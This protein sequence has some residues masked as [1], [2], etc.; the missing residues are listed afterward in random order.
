MEIRVSGC[1]GWQHKQLLQT[2]ASKSDAIGVAVP[3]PLASRTEKDGKMKKTPMQQ[4]KNKNS[5]QC[6]WLIV[7]KTKTTINN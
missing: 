5:N 2:I 4:E 6:V 1:I 7:K 3:Y